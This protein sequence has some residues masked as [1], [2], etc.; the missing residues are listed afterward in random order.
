[1][2]SLILAATLSFLIALHIVSPQLINEAELASLFVCLITVSL[3]SHHYSLQ[4][5]QY[6]KSI[7][8]QSEA[9]TELASQDPMTG[10][11]NRRGL[12]DAAMQ[13]CNLAK[14]NELTSLTLAVFDIDFLKP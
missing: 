11:L 2:A 13:Y 12:M 4:I 1:M 5:N 6:E 9:L 14:R 7:Q 8:Q 3:L 10:I